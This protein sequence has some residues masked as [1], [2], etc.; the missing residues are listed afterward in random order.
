MA[1]AVEKKEKEKRLNLL[2]I[3]RRSQHVCGSLKPRKGR[4][5]ISSDVSGVEPTFLLNFSNDSTL[6]AV[7][8]DYVG[9][10]PEWKDGI[11]LSD[12]LYV[13]T[14]SKTQLLGPTLESLPS[15]WYQLW[16]SNNEEAKKQLGKY[17]KLAKVAVLALLYGQTPSGVV[18]SFAAEGMLISIEEAT[19]L[20]A[21]FWSSLPDAHKFMLSMQV[22]F[23]RAHKKKMPVMGPFG[24]PIPSGKPKDAANRIIQS[25]VSCFI[26]Q[27]CAKVFPTPY[28][29]LTCIIHDEL[30]SEVLEDSVEEYK[31]HLFKALDETNAA[32][33]LTY[34]LRLG[35]NVGHNFYEIH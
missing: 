7:L 29:E 8:Q 23:T 32:F 15:T 12:S 1:K 20:H 25:S 22:M 26:R 24:F 5:F 4:V 33:A 3:N 6:K 2:S 31:G 35:F 17:Y 10:E 21:Q 28:A 13:T 18:K 27:L 14:M 19:T 34:P 16:L 9:K 11:L 30:I